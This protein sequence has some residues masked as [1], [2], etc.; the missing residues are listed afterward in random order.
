MGLVMAV[1]STPADSAETAWRPLTV[2]VYDGI[3]LSKSITRGAMETAA[4]AL[5]PA[6]I[7]VT[8]VTCTRSSGGRCGTPIG[9]GEV[10]VRLVRGA[11][12]E[13][14]ASDELLG[15]ALVDPATG[16]GVLATVYVER[17]ERMALGAGSDIGTLLGRAM[18]HEIGHL[19]LG[20]GAHGV[21][22]LMRPRWTREEVV[23]NVRA[24][25]GFAPLEV[26]TIRARF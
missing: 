26:E 3:G 20:G 17:V 24:D 8:W 23:R 5:R 1:W 4:Q 13:A 25:W 12:P 16:I 14:G 19:L 18:A 2:R 15:S 10:I 11:G 6:S 9:R 7:E 22:G 21:S